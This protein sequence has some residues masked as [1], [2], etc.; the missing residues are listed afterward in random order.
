MIGPPFSRRSA[1]GRLPGRC[2]A[3]LVFLPLLVFL[4]ALAPGRALAGIPISAVALEQA[5]DRT[6]IVLESKAEIRF[7]LFIF[8]SPN[9]VVLELEGVA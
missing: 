6:R 9:R 5:G 3:W 4:L 8:R 2:R 1:D 7:S